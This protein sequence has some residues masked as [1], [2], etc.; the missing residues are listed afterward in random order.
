MRRESKLNEY[1][2]HLNGMQNRQC[3][4]EL[5]GREF[6]SSIKQPVVDESS[7]RKIN[8]YSSAANAKLFMG[9]AVCS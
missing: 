3:E 9:F 5:W 4:R 7:D 8:F 6:E 1:I 2:Y